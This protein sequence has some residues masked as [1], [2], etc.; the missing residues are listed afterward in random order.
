MCR[1]VKDGAVASGFRID[2]LQYCNWSR[3]IF[4]QMREAELDAVHVTATYWENT[5][6]LLA[7]IG[8]WHRYFV[9]HADLIVPVRSAADIDHARATKRTGIVLGLQNCSPIEDS[10]DL[11]SVLKELNVHIMQL[12]YN[13]QSLLCTGYAEQ[14]DSGLTKF[15]REV[16]REMNRVGMVVD[17]SHTAERST[18]EAIEFSSRPTVISHANPQ[19]ARQTARNKSDRVMRALAES[20]GLMGFSCYPFHLPNGSETTLE[21][22][23]TMVAEAVEIMGV[24][25]LAIGTDL[26]QDQP[27]EVLTWMRNGNWARV[28]DYGEGSEEKPDWPAP[29]SWLRGVSDFPKIEQGLHDRGFTSSEVDAL[30]GG[31]WRSF[32]EHAL[33][34]EKRSEV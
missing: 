32:L 9:E 15:G 34:P 19:T 3:R 6:E 22:F 13:N 23:T 24:Q 10:V 20:G 4:E 29:L 1:L 27:V 11:V 31:N 12:S 18:L 7:N 17:T 14:Q 5:R 30:M 26:C 2:G 28:M 33:A 21:Q 25:H 16:I 8:T